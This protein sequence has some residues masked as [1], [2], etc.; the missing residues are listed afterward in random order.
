MQLVDEFECTPGCSLLKVLFLA[1]AAE[2]IVGYSKDL[3]DCDCAHL[4][5]FYNPGLNY[6]SH[7][8]SGYRFRMDVAAG[9]KGEYGRNLNTWCPH[10]MPV[11]PKNMPVNCL[12]DCL[13]VADANG[14][15]A[16]PAGSVRFQFV[17]KWDGP[18]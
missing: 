17:S 2:A 4:Q 6:N 10:H 3:S 11:D 13:W 14:I 12:P 5:D 9:P 8:N 16:A 1:S 15:S 18:W 7:L